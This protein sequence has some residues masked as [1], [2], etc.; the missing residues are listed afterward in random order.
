MLNF[1]FN[2]EFYSEIIRTRFLSIQAFHFV[3]SSVL[4]KVNNLYTKYTTEKR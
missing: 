2:S 3:Y 1:N 4:I